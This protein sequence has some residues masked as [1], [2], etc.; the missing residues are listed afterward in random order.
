M[1]SVGL[2]GKFG[3]AHGRGGVSGGNL[4]TRPSQRGISS[5]KTNSGFHS[6]QI[7][8]LVEGEGGAGTESSFQARDYSTQHGLQKITK[9]N[10]NDTS[11]DMDQGKRTGDIYNNSV[12]V[13][14]TNDAGNVARGKSGVFN[15]RTG[16]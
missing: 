8:H 13:I 14:A 9:L 2:R 3:S 15:F 6:F 12:D 5:G 11:F 10:A 16:K 7:S 1:P 4:Y